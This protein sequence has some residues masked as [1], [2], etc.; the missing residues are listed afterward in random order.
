[1]WI[2]AGFGLAVILVPLAVSA[3]P[4]AVEEPGT[5]PAL[6]P[7]GSVAVDDR[8]SVQPTALWQPAPAAPPAAVPVAPPMPP[9]IASAATSPFVTS[10]FGNGMLL[11]SV[12]GPTRPAAVRRRL[13]RAPDMFGDG[14]PPKPLL[15]VL[16]AISATSAI[17]AATDLPFAGGVAGGIGHL[18]IGD[19]NK[20]IPV[21]RVYFN[22][23]HFHN[24]LA[25]N[26][27]HGQDINQVLVT[28]RYAD[29]L[30]LNRYTLG[31]EKTFSEGTNSLEVRVPFATSHDFRFAPFPI[32]PLSVTSVDGGDFGNVSLILKHMLWAS[33]AAVLS[34]GLGLEVPTG[35]DGHARVGPFRYELE[36]QAVHLH[37][38]LALLINDDPGDWF[39]NAIAQLDFAANGNDFSAAN[40]SGDPNYGPSSYLG[41]FNEQ[42]LLYLD[43]SAGYW[44]YESEVRQTVTG[45]AGVLELHYTHTLVDGDD[46]AFAIPGLIGTPAGGLVVSRN[47]ADV[48]NLT[49]GVHIE[50]FQ[51]TLLRI[52]AAA[53]LRSSSSGNRFFDAEVLAQLTQRF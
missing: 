19:N 37:P 4:P 6:A 29:S 52:A 50:L 22:Y 11:T 13:T 40:I 47:R 38:F 17:V 25:T 30:D 27:L 31:L 21:D 2:R 49:A 7:Q 44:L 16:Q 41:R 43:L 48:L 45:V 51:D 1:M 36:N 26:I 42:H 5:A 53:P 24:A 28:E 33:D 12:Y 10:G 9:T 20:A 32:E 46:I 14:L 18:K 23:N 35:S 39:I 34:T 15:N 8:D 3:A